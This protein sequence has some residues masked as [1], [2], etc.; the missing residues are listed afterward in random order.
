MTAKDA[1]MRLSSS[2]QDL[3]T[4]TRIDA[5]ER[6]SIV[7]SIL[8]SGRAKLVRMLQRDGAVASFSKERTPP[9]S[10]TNRKKC[11][12]AAG[13]A[14]VLIL[15]VFFAYGS[16]RYFHVFLSVGSSEY[17]VVLDCGS[18]GQEFMSMNGILIIMTQMHF[19]LF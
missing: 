8:S 14:I 17:Y 3:P 13:C 6:G 11:M 2:L 4:F 10:P 16:W 1:A 18:T 12:R 7:G 19:L 5:L 9:S 15:L